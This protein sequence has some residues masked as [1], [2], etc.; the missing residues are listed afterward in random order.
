MT[1]SRYSRIGLLLLLV[2]FF[3][4]GLY[5]YQN[6]DTIL[7]HQIRQSLRKFGVEDYELKNPRLNQGRFKVDRFWLRG[8]YENFG[9]EATATSMEVRYD[10]RALLTRKVQSVSLSDLDV[11]VHQTA[12]ASGPDT[13]SDPTD[14]N[15]ENLLPQKLTSQ[16]PLQTLDIGKW[17]IDFQPLENRNYTATGKLLYQK[18]LDLSIKMAMANR[19]ITVVVE[20]D[21]DNS[22]IDVN[23]AMPGTGLETATLFAQV[24]PIARSKLEWRVQG[25]LHH[26][27]ALDWLQHLSTEIAI[28]LDIAIPDGFTLSGSSEFKAHL[29]HPKVLNTAIVPS[30]SMLRSWDGTIQLTSNFK[31]LNYPSKIEDLGGTLN[32][33]LEFLDGK[34]HASVEPFEITGGLRSG[35]L[36][37]SKDAQ[38]W[39]NWQETVPFLWTSQEP[40][41]IVS[42]EGKLSGQVGNTRLQLGNTASQFRL[43]KLGLNVI[44]TTDEPLSL[45]TQLTTSFAT[46]LRKQDFPS[47]TL[48][49]QQ[50]GHVEQSSYKLEIIDGDRSLD[51]D[52]QGTIDLTSGDGNHRLAVHISSLP[53]L[54]RAVA[55]PLH[56][57][58]L[59]SSD[60][61]IDSGSVSLASTLNT[62]GG[63]TA[64]WA[65]ESRFTVKD[66]SGT[67]DEY[68]FNTLALAAHWTGVQHWKTLQPVELSLNRL[69]MGF[70]V[71]AI[72]A[73]A[74]LPKATDIAQPALRVD[75][76]S[77]DVFGG[78]LFLPEPGYWDF[79]APSNTLTLQAQQ[80]Q[81]AEIVALQQAE[82]IQAKGILEG[83]LPLTVTDG[84]IVLEKG[85]LR[86]LPPGG[87]IRYIANKASR[88][89]G[90]NSK[91]LALALDLLSDFQYEVLSS[92]V[93]LD[94]E[95]NLL[96]GL[97]LSGRNPARFD[98]RPVNFNINLEQN[99]DPL[100]QSLRLSD[101]LTEKI[102]NHLQ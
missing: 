42:E 102:E 70:E 5:L 73:R 24:Q 29:R 6:L 87:T 63:D 13:V 53:I 22:S 51:A 81:L 8:N 96:L 54:T 90:K 45:S 59:L 43:E 32:A 100:L 44:M 20:T 69:D 76:F 67:Y 66:V 64:D 92:A 57:L 58:G 34:L 17:K 2:G 10:W 52:L 82:D 30:W 85:Y 77:A 88:A 7:Q 56:N 80:W 72:E 83:K 78:Q 25:T 68:P 91:E 74:S 11:T 98:G 16:L 15:I 47:L 46:R 31:Q 36:T 48:A 23:I 62:I 97:S 18:H 37:I 1:L 101:K 71:H 26:N 55:P 21:E 50:Q 12:S 9:Y 49:L 75:A 89:L 61:E 35:L 14:L 41:K 79:S 95:G 28:P 4:F 39:L 40:L 84:R 33:S 94:K 27:S 86:A 38:L 93:E 99:L 3:G 60:L 65:Q 19:N